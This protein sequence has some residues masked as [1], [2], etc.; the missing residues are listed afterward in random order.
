MPQEGAMKMGKLGYSYLDIL[1][2]YFKNIQI[3]DLQKLDF[4]KD[5]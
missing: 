5:E 3:I 2:F 1:D 4:F